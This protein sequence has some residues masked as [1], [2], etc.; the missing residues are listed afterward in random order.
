MVLE[1]SA[2]PVTGGSAFVLRAETE[3]PAH[4]EIET[5]RDGRCRLRR[6]K[7]SAARLCRRKVSGEGYGAQGYEE[8]RA[9]KRGD[10][11]LMD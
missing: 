6:R 5:V 9:K 8:N 3:A 4:R 7:A 10:H 1:A 2:D 11:S